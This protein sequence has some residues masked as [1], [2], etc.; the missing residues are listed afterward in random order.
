LVD[1]PSVFHGPLGSG[2]RVIGAFDHM[3]ELE[4]QAEDRARG[5]I[6]GEVADQEL[7]P[8]DR[9]HHQWQ[10]DRPSMTVNASNGSVRVRA[11]EAKPTP[12]SR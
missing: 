9:E 11:F 1:E 6:H 8:V 7:P 4:D 5:K 10:H 2:Q 12:M 3:R